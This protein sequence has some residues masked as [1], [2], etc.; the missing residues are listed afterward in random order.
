M[1]ELLVVIAIIGVLIALLLPAVQAAREAARRMQCTN[2]FKQIGL[3]LQNY[4]DTLGTFPASR[5]PLPIKTTTGGRH[6]QVSPDPFLFP[7][8]EQ[9]AAWDG[10]MSLDNN[11]TD[12]AIWGAPSQFTTGPFASWLCPSDPNSQGPGN[13]VTTYAGKGTSRTNVR[14]CM[15][16]GIWNVWEDWDANVPAN[17]RVYPRGMFH[18]RHFKSL[19]YAT[20]GTSNTVAAG[21]RCVADATGSGTTLVTPSSHVKHGIVAANATTSLYTGST[22]VPANC[23]NNAREP[24]DRNRIKAPA[25]SWN[26]QIFGD[27]RPANGC[28]HT[29]LPP[30]SPSCG[31]AISGGGDGWALITSSSFHSGGANFVFCDGSVH[32][33]SETINTGDLTKPQGGTP[34][35]GSAPCQPGQS[36]YGVWGALGTPQGGE[37]ASL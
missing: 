25:N 1:V 11:C 29:A 28:F 2:N 35:T 13:Y 32:F 37:S 6:Y 27:G 34:G 26:G 36:N 17:P 8:C 21:E 3:G 22:P 9:T 5:Q 19:T 7:F 20:D 10:I 4:H 33:V 14:Y 24:T 30:N 12:A 15:G 18:T 31:Y 23:L 16:D